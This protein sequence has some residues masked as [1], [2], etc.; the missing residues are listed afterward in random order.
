VVPVVA[1]SDPEFVFMTKKKIAK[2]LKIVKKINFIIFNWQA[3]FSIYDE[4]F[5]KKLKLKKNY[6]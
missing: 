1:D 5:L 3:G 6:F 4:N 2:K